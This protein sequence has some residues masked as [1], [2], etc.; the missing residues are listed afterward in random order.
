VC[1]DFTCRTDPVFARARLARASNP[2]FV[3]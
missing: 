2:F 3:Q 1:I